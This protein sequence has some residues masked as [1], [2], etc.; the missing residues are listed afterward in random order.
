MSR[1]FCRASKCRIRWSAE[2]WHRARTGWDRGFQPARS[3]NAFG[4][5]GTRGRQLPGIPVVHSSFYASHHSE[6]ESSNLSWLWVRDASG[7][8]TDRGK[9]GKVHTPKTLA[10]TFGEAKESETV[11]LQRLGAFPQLSRILP[12]SPNLRRRWHRSRPP[13]IIR[14][15]GAGPGPVVWVGSHHRRHPRKQNARNDAGH[16]VLWRPL[17]D[18]CAACRRWPF[19]LAGL[20]PVS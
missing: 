14:A 10:V 20:R 3:H 2:G 9:T 16:S 17:G 13:L 7:T 15:V 1:D 11:G 5:A 12:G 18:D 8:P 4:A 6:Y 19:G